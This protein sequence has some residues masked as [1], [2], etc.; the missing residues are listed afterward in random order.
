M[1]DLA[2]VEALI[3]PELAHEIQVKTPPENTQRKVWMYDS[4][5][6]QAMRDDYWKAATSVPSR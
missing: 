6:P 4:I 2:L 1:W 3:R 5:Q